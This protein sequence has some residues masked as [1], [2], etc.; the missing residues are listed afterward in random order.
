MWCNTKLIINGRLNACSKAKRAKDQGITIAPRV[1]YIPSGPL[2][3]PGRPGKKEEGFRR[4]D[5]A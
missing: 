3:D 1:S 5:R 2:P 4:M